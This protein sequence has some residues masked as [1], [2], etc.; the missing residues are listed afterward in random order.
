MRIWP[1]QFW[2]ARRFLT[3]I[4]PGALDLRIRRDLRASL[5]GKV[6]SYVE[7]AS[8]SVY[9]DRSHRHGSARLPISVRVVIDS[10]TTSST[11]T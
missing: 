10:R 3:E 5:D 11:P 2:L 9:G 7:G 4:L 1:E 6:V 8:G